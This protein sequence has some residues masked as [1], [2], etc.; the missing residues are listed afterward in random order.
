MKQQ[1]S[2]HFTRK[3][4]HVFVCCIA[5]AN[6]IPPDAQTKQFLQQRACLKL[7]KKRLTIF[8]AARH[9]TT[10]GYFL[11]H[12]KGTVTKPIISHILA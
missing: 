10:V 1:V 9:L 3:R 6:Q 4:F 7:H 11:A 8:T 2:K 5:K 12:D